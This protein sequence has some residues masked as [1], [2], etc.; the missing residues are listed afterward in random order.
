ML[1]NVCI[2]KRNMK[3][4]TR[5]NSTILW[6]VIIGLIADIISKEIITAH[7]PLNHSVDVWGEFFKLTYIYNSGVAFGMFQN[8]PGALLIIN[9]LVMAGIIYFFR[10]VIFSTH[11][12]SK[13][14]TW[15]VGM[16]LSGALGNNLDRIRFGSVRDFLD[17]DFPDFIMERWPVFNVADSLICVGIAFIL[18][19]SFFIESKL[20][21]RTGGG[22]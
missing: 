20:L 16:I 17:F 22:E 18:F 7:I 6:I 4:L 14:L 13:T 12:T 21:Q 11:T 1:Y 15:A 9:L 3:K 8:I 10:Q 19:Y 5:P 2:V